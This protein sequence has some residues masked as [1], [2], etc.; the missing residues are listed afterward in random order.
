VCRKFPG[1]PRGAE[2]PAAS[3]ALL[4]NAPH[5][6]RRAASHPTIHHPRRMP[7]NLRHTTLATGRLDEARKNALAVEGK[8]NLLSVFEKS[9]FRDALRDDNAALDY[10]QALD[11]ILT[12]PAI[13]KESFTR[14][15]DVVA[16]L[17]SEEGKWSP[18][19]WTIAT[20]LPF[21]AEPAR[22]MFL[23]PEV[24]QDCAARLTFDLAYDT[25]L[26]WES[27][28]KLLEMSS[29]LLEVLQPYGARDFIGV[30]SF[31]WLIGSGWKS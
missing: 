17:P 7:G 8:I 3:L 12:N 24:T 14:Y 16:N 9:S 10:F 13:E 27:Y 26:N 5:C 1:I 30:Q 21:I 6:L 31:I 20:L 28:S 18:A 2:R 23:K 22:F 19:K 29:Y 15:L 4:N 25:A 11:S